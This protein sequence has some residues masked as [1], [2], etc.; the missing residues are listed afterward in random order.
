MLAVQ[1]CL[2]AVQRQRRKLVLAVAASLYHQRA[3]LQLIDVD[4]RDSNVVAGQ[5]IDQDS[6]IVRKTS[7]AATRVKIAQPAM[8]DR[9]YLAWRQ[10]AEHLLHQ[11][12]DTGGV[13]L[14]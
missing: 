7:S 13:V 9:A 11:G 3:L 5:T 4:E 6:H 12:I 14:Q 8:E 10:A 2:L 1:W